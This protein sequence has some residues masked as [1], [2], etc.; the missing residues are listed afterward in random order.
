MTAD[1][2]TKLREMV[3][4][5][6]AAGT[7][8][9]I[10]ITSGKGGV[11]KSSLALNL[12][13]ASAPHYK[14]T[15]LVDADL[16][17]ANLDVMC[18]V[19]AT[20]GLADVVAGRRRLYDVLTKTGFSVELVPGASGMAYLADLP[21]EERARLLAQMEMLERE[22]DLLILDTGAG[23]SKNVVRIAAA[24]DEVL[25]VTTPEPTSITDA[26]AAIKLISRQR[27]HGAVKLVVNQASSPSEAS[28][29]A[30]RIVS[31]SRRFLG[32]EV[33]W[34]GYI[35]TDAKVSQAVRLRRPL[36]VAFPGSPA[37]LCIQTIARGLRSANGATKRRGFMPRLR[38]LLGGGS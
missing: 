23:V 12:A 16:G 6:G 26:Y 15:V 9:V 35:L 19:S 7:A 22:A 10:A 2:A 36:T 1:Q 33:G 32:V 30:Q 5:T 37:S 4:T 38:R 34:A 11:G 28:K 21:D 25:V 14:R 31:V 3:R 13:V 17:L 20:A 8:R 24:A 27:E 18:G 29:V